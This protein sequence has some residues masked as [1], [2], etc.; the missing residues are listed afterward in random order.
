M[1]ALRQA[2]RIRAQ[3]RFSFWGAAVGEI[4]CQLLGLI[5]VEVLE[6][7]GT[8]AS[9]GSTS[10]IAQRCPI[11]TPLS[12]GTEVQ[13]LSTLPYIGRLTVTYSSDVPRAR[14]QQHRENATAYLA[15]GRRICMPRCYIRLVSQRQV[16]RY[17]ASTSQA[18]ISDPPM[19][20]V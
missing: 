17:S 4:M 5:K 18:Q 7:M 19:S 20:A 16:S 10:S 6:N 1:F 2:N 13:P 11:P 12:G 14:Q 3:T 9:L 15:R 8:S